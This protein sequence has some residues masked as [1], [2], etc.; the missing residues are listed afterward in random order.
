MKLGDWSFALY[1]VHEL[2]LRTA[3]E[4]EPEGLAER[5]AG[6]AERA[7]APWRIHASPSGS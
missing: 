4:L 2:V 6:L 1:L 3:R 7:A 5:A